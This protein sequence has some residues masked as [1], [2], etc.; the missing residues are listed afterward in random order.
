MTFDPTWPPTGAE[1]E[2][3]PFR[4]QFNGLKDLIDATPAGPTGPKGDKG[5]PGN[6]G[7]A[8]PQGEQGPPGAPIGTPFEGTA[9][10][11][12]PVLSQHSFSIILQPEGSASSSA[13]RLGMSDSGKGAL[14]NLCSMT[15]GNEGPGV[16]LD[17]CGLYDGNGNASVQDGDLL[18]YDAANATW[19]PVRPGVTTNIQIPDGL[20]G[21]ISLQI[22][23]G[24]IV[25][26]N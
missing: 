5:D 3:E 13:I 7:A 15:D 1:L 20:G 22:V 10:F 6:D 19:K 24:L 23:G 17:P 14:L 25:A 26:V 8:G 4:N 11:N 21:V 18:R 16:N 12:G 2:S 9:V